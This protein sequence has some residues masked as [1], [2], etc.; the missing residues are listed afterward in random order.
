MILGK[1]AVGP[2][3]TVALVS[4]TSSRDHEP[5]IGRGLTTDPD[6]DHVPYVS[7]EAEQ[8]RLNQDS[9]ESPE[10][11]GPAAVLVREL[12]PHGRHRCLGNHH[13]SFG[14]TGVQSDLIGS[15]TEGADHIRPVR[16]RQS[17]RARDDAPS[18]L[19]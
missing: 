4:R 1:T 19:T 18:G 10:Q 13:G 7:R 2:R 15:H 8:G 11:A 5:L 17:R 9:G 6:G 16:K 3:P 12:G 14:H